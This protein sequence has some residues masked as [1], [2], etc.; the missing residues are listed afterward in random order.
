MYRIRRIVKVFNSLL[1]PSESS[2]ETMLPDTVLEATAKLSRDWSR[3]PLPHECPHC[4]QGFTRRSLL[5]EHVFLHTGEKLFNCSVCSKSF[6]TPAGLLRHSL[7]HGPSRSFT[8]PICT[9]P[10]NQPASL[11]RHMLTHQEGAPRRGHGSS[12]ARGRAL[13]DTRLLTCPDCPASFM[14]DAQLQMHR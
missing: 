2:T 13:G 4:G 12:K 9:K 11:K 7:C 3:T 10:F 8:C 1:R 6:P 5:R 14:L